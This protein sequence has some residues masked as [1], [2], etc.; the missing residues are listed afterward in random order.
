MLMV[1]VMYMLVAVRDVLMAVLMDMVF[2]QMQPDA[3]GHQTSG[4]QQL[5]RDRL[6]QQQHGQ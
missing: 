2:S 6:V 3:Q 4:H 5:G 1:L